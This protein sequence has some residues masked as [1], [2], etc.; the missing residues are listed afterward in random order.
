MNSDTGAIQ[1]NAA[2]CVL[3]KE[4]LLV[5]LAIV[6]IGMPHAQSGLEILVKRHLPEGQAPHETYLPFYRVTCQKGK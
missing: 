6:H 3:N 2:K 5:A 1:L 4:F